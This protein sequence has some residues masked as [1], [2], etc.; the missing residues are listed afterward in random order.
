MFDERYIKILQEIREDVNKAEEIAR[1]LEWDK[2]NVKNKL[3]SLRKRGMI[4]TTKSGKRWK[5]TK[6][7]RNFI[8]AVNKS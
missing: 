7:G 8:K 6:R 1:A 3:Y 2:R 4:K 5:L